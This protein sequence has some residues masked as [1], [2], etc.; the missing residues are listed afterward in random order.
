MSYANILKSVEEVVI[1]KETRQQPLKE[2]G[3]FLHE[4]NQS[5]TKQVDK[6]NVELTMPQ[7]EFLDYCSEMIFDLY[8]DL[9]QEYSDYGL[10][11]VIDYQGFQEIFLKN[12]RIEEVYDPS[13]DEHVNE[14]D[15]HLV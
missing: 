13:D 12:I 4:L 7:S 14:N 1:Q 6:P 5:K 10:F 9:R 11:H 8:Y 15:D 3:V 2:L